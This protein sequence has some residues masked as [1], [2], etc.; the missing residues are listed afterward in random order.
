MTFYCINCW[1]EIDEGIIICPNCGANQEELDKENYV[2]KLIR[3][4][5]HPEPSTPARAASILARL[6]AKEA[7]QPMLEKLKTEKDPFII[8]AFAEAILSLDFTLKH[9][10]M[11]IVGKNLPIILKNYLWLS[12]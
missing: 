8:S 3:S 4:L 1:E 11:K 10:I 5:N 2:K 6:N 12:K 9:E 7:I